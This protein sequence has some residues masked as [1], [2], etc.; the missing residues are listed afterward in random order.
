MSARPNH[1]DCLAAV[2][3]GL[4]GANRMLATP[5]GLKPFLY[6]DYTASGR[7]LRQIERQIDKLMLD[8]ANPHSEDSATGRASNRWM[9]DAEAVIRKAVNAG[10]GDCL[11]PCAAGATGAIHKLQEILGLAVAPASRDALGVAPGAAVRTVV[12]VGPYEHHSNELSWRDSLAEVVSIPLDAT[13]GIDLR[14][15]EAALSEPRFEGWR[16]IGA[17]SAASNVTGIRTDIV[18]LAHRLHAHG[19]IL[20]LDC[21]ASAPYQRIDMHPDQD[22]ASAI[23]AVYFSPHKFIGGPGS[24]GI[25]VFNDRLYRRDLAPTQSAG[26]TVRY[27]WQ[28]GHDFLEGIEARER[29][30]TPGLPQLVRAALA[31]QVQSEIG[32]EVIGEREHGALERAFQ[33]WC[34]HPR[35][36]VLGPQAPSRRLGIVAFNLRKADGAVVE[37]RLVTLLLND[38]FGIQSRAGCSCAGP[39]GHHLLGIDADST[40]SIRSRV[41]D[42]DVGARP[43]WCRVSLHWVMS[44]DEIDYLIDAVCFLADHAGLFSGFYDRDART[45]SWRWAGDPVGEETGWPDSLLDGGEAG[46]DCHAGGAGGD[47]SER[48]ETPFREARDLVRV[49][50]DPDLH[51]VDVQL[52]ES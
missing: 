18:S 16:K 30:G 31:L 19:A 27:V 21:A 47:E 29:A 8:Y 1:A 43:G 38:L 12:F 11:L 39:Y 13:G 26:G 7:A 6:A 4:I 2:R 41:L 45:G 52:L 23:D 22:P 33:R 46:P 25:L 10:P 48:Y 3:D 42:G 50:Q 20:C 24:C 37:P 35:I 17:F 36:E 14:A 34:Q 49:F 5:F 32:P 51:P 40:R 15:L 28:D 9:R 44:D